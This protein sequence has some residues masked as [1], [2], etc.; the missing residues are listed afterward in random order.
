MKVWKSIDGW[1]N[2]FYVK[3]KLMERFTR[4]RERGAENELTIHRSHGNLVGIDFW[5]SAEIRVDRLI[6]LREP[7]TEEES[8]LAEFNL[9]IKGFA[10]GTNRG[11]FLF[12]GKGMR[13]RISRLC[14][15]LSRLNSHATKSFA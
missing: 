5:R 4:E 9:E 8:S 3:L 13:D 15:S 12:S 6:E 10:S 7:E 1:I 2:S 11:S 14:F